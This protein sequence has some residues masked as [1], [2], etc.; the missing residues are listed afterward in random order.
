M[1]PPRNIFGQLLTLLNY[2]L[3]SMVEQSAG[4]WVWYLP[5]CTGLLRPTGS[6]V[7]EPRGEGDG[8][9]DPPPMTTTRERKGVGQGRGRKGEGLVPVR[10]RGARETSKE[11]VPGRAVPLWHR[12]HLLLHWRTVLYIQVIHLSRGT[13]ERSVSGTKAVQFLVMAGYNLVMTAHLVHQHLPGCNLV[14]T[15]LLVHQNL[16]G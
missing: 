5:Q 12:A 13:G 2:N 1:K 4:V 9:L 6:S 8:R 11:G 7:T 14:M 15:D 16:P 10:S 3:P